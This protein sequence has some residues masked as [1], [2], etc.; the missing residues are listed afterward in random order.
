MKKLFTLFTTILLATSLFAAS[1]TVT[2]TVATTSTVSTTGTAPTGSSA[3]Y[4]QTYSTACQMTKN[5][6]ETLTLK[7]LGKINITNLTLSM[8]SNS[9]GG[10]GSLA[11]SVDG[12]AN[13]TYL[14]G[15]SSS[16]V[17]FDQDAWNGAWSTD[18]VNISKDLEITNVDSLIIKIKATANRIRSLRI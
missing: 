11:Y 4:T 17:R 3:S 13:Y 16:G 12:G 10:A 1:K 9:S 14:V 8:K 6:S 15:T 2:Y 18:Y 7:N 5:N